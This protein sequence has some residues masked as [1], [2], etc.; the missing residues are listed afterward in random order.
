MKL[1]IPFFQGVSNKKDILLD[2]CKKNDIDIKQVAYIGNDIND[3]DA[4]VVAGFSFCPKDSH[5]NI[6]EIADHILPRNGGD[7]VIR[8]LFDIIQSDD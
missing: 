1:K 3:I 2:H 6:K 7:G 5:E 4:M 8:D